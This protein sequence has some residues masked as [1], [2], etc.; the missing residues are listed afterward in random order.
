MRSRLA[1]PALEHVAEG[2]V[3]PRKFVVAHR[4]T[5]RGN[6]RAR[7]GHIRLDASILARPAA[8]EICHHLLAR[9]VDE[10]VEAV[11]LRCA[12]GD[13]V[14][15]HGGT[16]DGLRPRTSVTRREFQNIR[17][18]QSIRVAHQ[19]I[20]LRRADVVATLRVIAPTVRADVR[21][22]LHRVTREI[23]ETRRRFVAA[24]AVENALRDEVRARR[25]AQSP[26]RSV[27]VGLAGRAIGRDDAGAVCAVPVFIRGIGQ[28]AVVEQ[29]VHPPEQIGMHDRDVAEMQAAVRHRH[30]HAAAVVA[31]RLD[32]G[33]VGCRFTADDLRGRLVE[34]P[35]LG[36][37][38]HPEHRVG[39]GQRR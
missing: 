17:R 12:R 32:V 29:S 37:A 36:R 24:R 30:H 1:R 31:E 35:D 27:V 11:V 2:N 16:A 9:V 21:P 39:L 18:A 26:E 13:D 19:R 25:H 6:P 15:G 8:G 23:K 14:L 33:G 34:H 22:G 5:Q 38:F 3:G 7:R 4:R 10:I 20:K 28:C